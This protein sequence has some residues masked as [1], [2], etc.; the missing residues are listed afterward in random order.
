MLKCLNCNTEIQDFKFIPARGFSK[1]RLEIITFI[2]KHCC[3]NECY[4]KIY[5]RIINEKY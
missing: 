2:R 3:S 1:T 5:E 4:E